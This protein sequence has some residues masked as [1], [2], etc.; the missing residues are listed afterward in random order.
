MTLAACL[1]KG[2]EAE[3]GV[4]WMEG[5]GV[6]P[7]KKKKK[8]E[9]TMNNFLKGGAA[10]HS[11][12]SAVIGG[13]QDTPGAERTH[14]GVKLPTAPA[15]ETVPTATTATSSKAFTDSFFLFLIFTFLF[16]IDLWTSR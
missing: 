11:H 2:E 8:V 15:A 14:N 7:K 4:T 13:A 3:E 16:E 5:G 1:T 6:S 10:Y 12:K 9:S